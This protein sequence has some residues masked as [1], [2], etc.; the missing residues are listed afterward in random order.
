MIQFFFEKCWISAYELC[1]PQL[2]DFGLAITGGSPR[3]NN[4]KL[5]G[6]LGY[7]APEYLLDG[8]A[9]LSLCNLHL[10]I[11]VLANMVPSRELLT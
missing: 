8:K 7:V 3:K 4:I 6:T 5:T 1:C 10:L 2:S 11:Y 9:S